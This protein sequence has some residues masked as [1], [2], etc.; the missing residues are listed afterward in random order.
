MVD[1]FKYSSIGTLLLGLLVL[2]KAPASFGAS[3]GLYAGLTL[4]LGLISII[5]LVANIVVL[6]YF[7]SVIGDVA[8]SPDATTILNK[9][10]RT[11]FLRW[12]FLDTMPAIGNYVYLLL[13]D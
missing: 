2:L 6:T 8:Q 13:L 12:G 5:L 1:S 3:M 4:A 10:F 9:E 7:A 11:V